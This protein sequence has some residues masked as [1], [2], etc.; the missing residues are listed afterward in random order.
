[1]ENEVMVATANP[2]MLVA[3]IA[4]PVYLLMGLSLLI[5]AKQWQKLSG[6]WEKDHLALFTMML[7]STVLGL[8]VIHYY[9]VWEWN[10]WLLV[11]LTG[12]CLFLKGVV[13]LLA[14]G[15]VIKGLLSLGKNSV[16]LYLGGLVSLVVGAVLTYYVY[17]V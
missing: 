8:L 5:Y 15:S 10:V 17:W 9:N 3:L 1:M 7:M 16:L 6:G 12:W 2:A 14:P 11:T 13:Y 4:G